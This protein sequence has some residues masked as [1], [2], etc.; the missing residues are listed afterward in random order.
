M[1]E[2]VENRIYISEGINIDKINASK[3]V[4][5]VIMGISKDIGLKNHI[6]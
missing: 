4:I 3:N 5:F 1:V 2:Y 6:I